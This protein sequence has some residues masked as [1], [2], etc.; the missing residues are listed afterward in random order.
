MPVCRHTAILAALLFAA[1]PVQAQADTAAHPFWTGLARLVARGHLRVIGHDTTWRVDGVPVTLRPLRF[2]IDRQ[3]K[4]PR[5]DSVDFHISLFVPAA[6]GPD[7]APAGSR[8]AEIPWDSLFHD[9]QTTAYLIY[10]QQDSAGSW[11]PIHIEPMPR[12]DADIRWLDRQVQPPKHKSP[13]LKTLFLSDRS[14]IS[15]WRG[16]IEESD[17]ASACGTIV[18]DSALHGGDDYAFLRI[19]Y[20]LPLRNLSPDFPVTASVGVGT[21]RPNDAENTWV[22]QFPLDTAYVWASDN[23]SIIASL[24]VSKDSLTGTWERTCYAGC[25]EHGAIHFSRARP[26][27]GAHK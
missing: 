21:A 11:L 9:L 25:E 22:V 17:R 26:L 18:V 16:C 7:G 5:L 10:A 2:T 20:A 15:S 1:R 6:L 27:T 12:A 13:N 23:G 14:V 3:W 19:H 24:K 8:D 4:G